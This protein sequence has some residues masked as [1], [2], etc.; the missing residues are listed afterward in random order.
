MFDQEDG[1]AVEL[2][3]MLWHAKTMKE[4]SMGLARVTKTAGELRDTSSIQQLFLF[5]V[6]DLFRKGINKHPQHSEAARRCQRMICSFKTWTVRPWH[7]S[8]SRWTR[9][10]SD[11]AFSCL[12]AYAASPCVTKERGGPKT[13]CNHTIFNHIVG[14]WAIPQICRSDSELS[15][16]V[17][18]QSPNC[19]FSI[20]QTTE[21]MFGTKHCNLPAIVSSSQLY[22][23]FTAQ[24]E[25]FL[26][27]G[28]PGQRTPSRMPLVTKKGRSLWWVP[29]GQRESPFPSI[30]HKGLEKCGNP[31][32]SSMKQLT[33]C[34]CV[35]FLI[36]NHP[37]MKG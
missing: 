2:L 17:I 36:M 18:V 35:V 26:G 20:Q 34:F 24:N 32:S 7:P 8:E 25:T 9:R 21:N 28:R 4:N 16:T 10:S 19:L 33:N 5:I 14:G 11:L 13:C 23:D 27:C 3:I 37:A 31:K 30:S 6:V 12:Q 22:G 29:S 1:D 15:Y